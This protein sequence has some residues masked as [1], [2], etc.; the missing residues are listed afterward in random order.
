[1]RDFAKK[2]TDSDFGSFLNISSILSQNVYSLKFCRFSTINPFSFITYTV[3]NIFH[4]PI[5]NIHVLATSPQTAR[6][7]DQIKCEIIP[8][9]FSRRISTIKQTRGIWIYLCLACTQLWYVLLEKWKWRIRPISS[10]FFYIFYATYNH[11]D[12]EWKTWIYCD[13]NSIGNILI[14]HIDITCSSI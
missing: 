12:W 7:R 6:P 1:M 11:M 3:L 10:I 5:S 2:C 13:P 4:W 9:L 8:L 14:H